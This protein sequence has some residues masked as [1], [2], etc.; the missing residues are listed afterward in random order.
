MR[1]LKKKKKPSSG[2]IKKPNFLQRRRARS[3]GFIIKSDE[4]IETMY[5]ANQI[6]AAAFDY[7]EETV[8]DGVV[9]QDLDRMVEEFI[10][11]Q[12]ATSLYKG[13]Q[14][15]PPSHP[16][17]P[18]T[19]CASINNEI[20]H[21][22]PNKRTLKNGDIIG[23]DIGL[24]YK[25]YCGDACY[26]FVIG[27]IPESTQQFL[28]VAEECLYVGIDMAKPNN[29]LGQIG[30]AIEDHATKHGYSIVREWGGHG[31][32]QS[33]HEPM[34]VPH[35]G[36]AAYGPRLKPGMTFTI[37]PMVNMGKPDCK[38]MPDGWTVKTV[39]GK[40]SAQFEHSIAI[41]KTGAR[42]LSKR[43]SK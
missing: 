25:N 14:G 28:K 42:I 8:E 5:A 24:R 1:K 40:L 34:S 12:G 36:P 9:L 33:L 41:T 39:D 15:N 21:G 17:F 3:N 13:Y 31:I 19:I 2:G 32:G 26:T 23:I 20:C 6:V 10:V 38:L 7:I 29:R 11:K 18:G 16:P 4:E 35:H 43:Q 30:Q 37:E 27:D 22:L